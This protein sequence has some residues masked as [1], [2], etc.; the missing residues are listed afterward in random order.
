M[1]SI[2]TGKNIQV[3]VFGQSHSK[4]IGAVIDGLP[5][6][7]SVDE[8]K[9]HAFMARRAP[10]RAK[11]A[12]S[13]KESDSPVVLSG[14]LNGATCGA[15]L[16]VMIENTNTRSQDY[17]NL[18]LTPRPAHS[19][20]AAAVRY[21]GFND[22]AGGGHFSGRLTAPLC[23][24][25]AICLQI[26]EEKGVAVRAHIASVAGIEDTP[27][28]KVN[29]QTDDVAAKAFPVLS[30]E[31]GEKMQAAIEKARMDCDSVGGVIECAVVGLPAGIGDP[32]FDGVE[33]QLAK[34]LFGIPA[35]KG[36][37]FGSGFAGSALRGSENND[38]FCVENG[39]IRTVTNNHGGILGGI[40]S[41]MPVVFRVAIKPTPSISK[42][43]QSVHLETKIEET[44][45]IVGRH[46]PCIVPRAVPVVE[47]V[48]AITVLDMLLGA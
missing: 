28:D 17:D 26:L 45:T 44:L 13:R 3:S 8:E 37:E 9:V 4:A 38:A 32:M 43:Q 15:P 20:Y 12:T 41:G 23:F 10:G 16:G 7:F 34:N 5:A 14:L 24:A 42:P 30:D 36:L 40:T 1:S 25:G 39:E 31:Q 22:I 2:L 35:V 6:G 46:D 19:D 29:I 21:N 18:R 33:N 27:Y 48:T 11:F 47:A